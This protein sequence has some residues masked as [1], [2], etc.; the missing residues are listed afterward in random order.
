MTTP[1]LIETYINGNIKEARAKAKYRSAAALREWF[2]DFGY[3][4]R[5]AMLN[6]YFLKTGE[7]FQAACDSR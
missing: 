7:G 3:S 6:T 4:E 5:A 1:E 2:E